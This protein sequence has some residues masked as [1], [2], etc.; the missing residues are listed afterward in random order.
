MGADPE[1]PNDVKQE[2][3]GGLQTVY[4]PALPTPP[5]IPS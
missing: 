3:R 2:G 4:A 5:P 1:P